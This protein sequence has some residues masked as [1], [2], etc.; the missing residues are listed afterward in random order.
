MTIT[1]LGEGHPWDDEPGWEKLSLEAD[2]PDEMRAWFAAH[3][4]AAWLVWI[5]SD[6]DVECVLYRKTPTC[7]SARD[8]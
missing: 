1:Q 7:T 8:Y 2:S 4:D 5:I 6:G 3:S